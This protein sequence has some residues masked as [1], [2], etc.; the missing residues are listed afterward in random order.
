MIRLNHEQGI[1]RWGDSFDYYSITV[2]STNEESVRT[3]YQHE[4]DDLISAVG[5]IDEITEAGW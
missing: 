2:F 4:K 3:Y 5:N 1:T